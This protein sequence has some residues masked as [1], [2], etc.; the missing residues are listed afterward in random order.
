MAVST[1]ARFYFDTYQA[2]AAGL[3]TVILDARTSE[4]DY[5]FGGLDAST[6]YTSGLHLEG[7]IEEVAAKLE[8]L[9]GSL[10]QDE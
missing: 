8:D 9:P 4:K 7:D 10:R 3:L 6:I 1:S 2:A 5:R